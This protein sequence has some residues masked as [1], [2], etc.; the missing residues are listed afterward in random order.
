MYAFVHVST[1]ICIH[2]SVVQG[3]PEI[4]VLDCTS[5]KNMKYIG[6]GGGGGVA[7]LQVYMLAGTIIM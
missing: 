3:W 4:A 1:S 2:T 5:L 7:G 6:K